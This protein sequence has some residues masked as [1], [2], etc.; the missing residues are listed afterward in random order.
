MIQPFV[1][2][3][4][5]SKAALVAEFRAKAP[6]SY[7]ALV[8]RLVELLAD[9]DAYDTP[10]PSRIHVIDDGDYQG[11]RLF[12]VG[13]SGYQPTAYWSIFVNYGSCSGCDTFQ[14][15]G[16]YS[17]DVSEEQAGEYYTLMLHMAQSMK[18]LR[19]EN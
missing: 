8:K 15:I 10:D 5:A 13:A 6:E 19:D 2:K 7:G 9:E 1:D 3:L 17:S 11:T 14:A 16:G 4:I 18:L 12:I